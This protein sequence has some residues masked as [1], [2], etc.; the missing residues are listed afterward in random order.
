MVWNFD[1]SNY[2]SPQFA[3]EKKLIIDEWEEVVRVEFVTPRSHIY[4]NDEQVKMS[5]KVGCVR[6][7]ST[8]KLLKS[9][10]CD[11]VIKVPKPNSSRNKLLH[12]P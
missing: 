1:Q 4:G 9:S 12:A 3:F 10:S 8:L 6:K 5:I 2:F 7:F 11:F